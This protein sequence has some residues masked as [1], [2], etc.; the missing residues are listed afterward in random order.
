MLTLKTD[1]NMRIAEI[2]CFINLLKQLDNSLSSSD[3]H[4]DGFKAMKASTHLLIYN[5][6]E[7]TA[8]GIHEQVFDAITQQGISFDQLTKPMK[9]IVLKNTQRPNVDRL[10]ADL[11]T[12]SFDIIG[13][14]FDRE[15]IY[16]GN[17]DAKKLRESFVSLGM[18]VPRPRGRNAFN[19]SQSLVKIKMN[20]NDLAHGRKTFAEVGR[21]MTP[22]DLANELVGVQTFLDQCITIAESFILN[23]DFKN[24]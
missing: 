16:S 1:F 11:K 12:L 8:T 21:D 3:P 20:R 13:K 2:N 19:G 7:S 9:C 14:T 18:R 4:Y 17:V 15:D 22:N 23:Q 6:V 24:P 5:L 10:V